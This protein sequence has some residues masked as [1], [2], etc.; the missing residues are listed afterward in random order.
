MT[1]E[2]LLA[3]IYKSPCDAMYELENFLNEI[4][5]SISD[6]NRGDYQHLKV[7]GNQIFE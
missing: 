4:D 3:T 6:E 5:K 1:L 2:Q 7:I